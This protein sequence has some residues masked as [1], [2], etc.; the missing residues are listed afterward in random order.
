M[1]ASGPTEPIL[2]V[3]LVPGNQQGRRHV[4]CPLR[5]S[6]KSTKPRSSTSSSE[7]ESRGRADADPGVG[8]RLQDMIGPPARL[9]RRGSR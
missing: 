8:Y 1:M 2:A 6:S 7:L 4:C 5:R 3:D 9:A